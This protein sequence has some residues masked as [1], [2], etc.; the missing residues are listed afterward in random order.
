MNDR[1]RVKEEIIERA[2]QKL[3]S[4]GITETTANY[5]ADISGVSKRTFYKYFPSVDEFL[6]QLMDYIKNQVHN[7][8]ASVLQ[9]SNK[10]YLLSVKS[11]FKNLPKAY[12]KNFENFMIHLHKQRPDL[13]KSFL[14]FRK[15]EFDLILEKLIN[16][17]EVNPKKRKLNKRVTRDILINLFEKMATP[18][19]IAETGESMDTV[20]HTISE[21]FFHGIITENE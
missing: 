2:Y 6:N 19:Y 3:L 7:E 13:I 14:D 9:S 16:L 8:F 10:N 18:Y 11:L 5:L 4:S 1:Y 15:N 17:P 20:V 21:I 12:G